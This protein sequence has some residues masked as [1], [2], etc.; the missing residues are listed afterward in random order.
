MKTFIAAALLLAVFTV[1]ANVSGTYSCQNRV[2]T[3]TSVNGKSKR[4][5]GV[6]SSTVTYFPDG[7]MEGR[8]PSSPFVT[9]GT[10]TQQ[11]SNLRAYPNIDDAARDSVYGCERVGATCLFVGAVAG[12]KARV[13]KNDAT[14]KGTTTMQITMIVNGILTNIR[15]LNKFSCSK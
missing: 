2:T 11:G 4:A 14:I 10:W 13:G 3:T 1:H 15:G 7:T 5:Y 9:R 6:S 8:T 12:A